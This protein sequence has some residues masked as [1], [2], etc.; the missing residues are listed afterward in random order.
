MKQASSN[1]PS[2]GHWT[3]NKLGHRKEDKAI[4]YLSYTGLNLLHWINDYVFFYIQYKVNCN[5]KHCY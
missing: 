1:M 3:E 2:E 5:T 4:C